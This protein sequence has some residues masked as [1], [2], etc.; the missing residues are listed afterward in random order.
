MPSE[1]DIVEK[2]AEAAEERIFETYRQSD[3]SDVDVTVQFIDRELTV[4]VY[5]DANAQTPDEQEREQATVEA[6]IDA[7]ERTVDRLV[8]RE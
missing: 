6:A 1:E 5:L 4:D 8:E 7:A 3:V 2:A